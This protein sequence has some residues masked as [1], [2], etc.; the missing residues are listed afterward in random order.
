[1][2]RSEL[3][4][5]E[6]LVQRQAF[7]IALMDRLR[8]LDNP[9]AIVAASV[10]M[11]GSR[12]DAGRCGFAIVSAD[13]ADVRVEADWSGSLPSLAGESRLLD[14]FGPDIIDELRRGRTLV[15]QDSDRDP[16]AAG[17]QDGWA[18]IG[19][20]AL[21][22]CPVLREGRLDSMLYL[23][24]ATPRIWTTSDIALVEDVALRTREA[25]DRAWSEAELR[26]SELRYRSLFNSID[27][28]FCVVEV[29]FNANGD[30][31]D[32][33]FLEVNSSFEQH[34][35]IKDAVGRWMRDI[36]PD[37][38]QHWFDLYGRIAR[39]GVSEQLE[40][41]ALR[42]HDRWYLVHAYRVDDPQDNHVA[43]LFSDLSE[44]RR[45][46]MALSRSRE[47]LELATRA[48]NLGRY[49]FHVQDDILHWDD[50]CRELFGLS[51]G[52]PVSYES[53]FLAGLHP[54]DRDAADR[55]V[56]AALD[57]DGNHRF[58][59]EYRTIGIE[60][61]ELRY[62]AAH[63]L[64]FFVDRQPTRLVGTVQDVSRD[65]KA[66][67]ALR[68]VEQRL[69]LAGRA[70]NDAVWD[71][72]LRSNHV[73]WNEALHRAY[74]HELSTVAPTGQWWLEHIHPDDRQ[75]IDDSIHSV[76]DGDGTDWSD[77]YRFHRA[78]GSYADVLDRGY[79]LRDAD[80]APSRM[81]GAMLDVSDRKAVERQLERER[82]RLREEVEATAAER[83]RAEEA[84]RQSQKMEA[85]GQLTG[86]IAHD[87]NNLLTGIS[88]ALEMIQIRIGQGRLNELEKYSVAAQGA[89]RRAAALTHRLLAFSRRQTLD[90][91][92]TDINRLILDIE[93][94]VQR[95]VGP[96][97]M[98]ESRPAHGLWR[99]LVD[100][101]QLENAILNLCIN[102][103]DAM[104]D[105]GRI[106]IE[107]ANIWLDERTARQWDMDMGAFVALHVRDTGTGMAPD[108]LSRAF[109]P[110]FTTKPIGQGTG[111]GLSM[112]YGFARQSGGQVRIDTQLGAGTSI[113]LYLP[114]LEDE[115][116][117]DDAGELALPVAS[118]AAP[119]A[120]RKASVLIV[121][122]DA[123]VRML[124]VEVATELG[125][126][127]VEAEDGPGAL[128]MLNKRL[129]IDLLITDVGL[130]GG[131]NGRQVADAAL[132]LIPTV[133]VLFITGYAERAAIGN[134][135]LASNM[136]VMTKPFA[137]DALAARIGEILE[138]DRT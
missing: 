2:P 63:G 123:T 78:D 28:G 77:E 6:E 104:P 95:T 96:Q 89:V 115:T 97:V 43:I 64:A 135:Q 3:L 92:P 48:A 80:G 7:Q 107:T 136:A 133:Q 113:C 49:D 121:D 94:M 10:K 69:R 39:T 62:I 68:E 120:G 86:G 124:A 129:D 13:G 55:A 11:L 67:A 58:E 118:L 37:H 61:G 47:E 87:F 102:A 134:D 126:E 88:G 26:A 56:R 38:E 72:D 109:D 81:V 108:V 101:N 66:N 130:P 12:L 60:D 32:Y 33:R 76:I 75:R 41:P 116:A 14:S 112:I 74:G 119:T 110:F 59:V 53:A 17:Y 30:A 27:A 71:W 50:R 4:S 54:D 15:V 91:R 138:P 83:D 16:R 99:S 137:M 45:S 24:H 18:S 22:V 98:V 40:L 5:R 84:L 25:S 82:Q 106:I 34:T 105:G 9:Q 93:D 21:I 111:L 90:P 73:A 35:G 57:P 103:R 85:V 132:R 125:H 42:L 1:M 52:A 51:P 8:L 70:T 79:V 131:L 100:S 44:R 20:R 29:K 117:V 128:A 114:R 127:V 23:H 36:A 65:R 31:L 122:D 19:T 46:E